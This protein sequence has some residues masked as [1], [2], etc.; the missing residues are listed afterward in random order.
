MDKYEIEY[1]YTDLGG[2]GEWLIYRRKFIFFGLIPNGK[3]CVFSS[4]IEDVLVEWINENVN[5]CTE[6]INLKRKLYRNQ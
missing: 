2:N 6:R 5:D 4:Q 3:E 1:D